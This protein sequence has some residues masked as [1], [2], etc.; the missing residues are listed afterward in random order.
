M[1]PE[2][3]EVAIPISMSLNEAF[4]YLLPSDL[5][6]AV[7]VGCRVIVPFR[8]ISI[9][10]YV[11]AIKKS[12]PYKDKLKNI[13]KNLDTEPP[14]NDEMFELADLLQKRYFCSTADAIHTVLP[15]GL[16]KSTRQIA[17]TDTTMRPYG[18]IAPI[19]EEE[20]S[21]LSNKELSKSPVL[22]HDLSDKKRWAAY[23]ALIK[24]ALAGKKSVIFMVPDHHK[25]KPAIERL[26]IGI[27]PL[28]LS[29]NIKTSES[30][31]AWFQAKNSDFVFLVGTRSAV[32]SPVN[33][34]GLIIIEEEDHFAYRQDQVP[35]Y[36]TA[37][38]AEHRARKHSAKL[39]CGS[40]MPSLESFHN[41]KTHSG[42]YIKFGELNKD[43][44][45]K[46]IDMK[47]QRR[48]KPKERVIS[49]VLEHRLAAILE[50]KQ[51]VLIFSNKKGFSTFLY[52]K[53]CN[54]TQTCPRCSTSLVYHFNEKLLSCPKCPHTQEPT[55]LC[56][57]C[58]SAYV[59][60]S[61]YGIEKVESEISR[62]FPSAKVAIYGKNKN[63]DYD[64]IL[65]TQN[66]LEDP[67][68]GRYSCDAVVALSCEQM[69]GHLDFHS[70]EKA[71][72]KLAK[73]LFLAK[74]EFLA[75]TQVMENSALDCLSRRDTE[76]FYS[77]ELN[78]RQ[79][80]SLPPFTEIATLLIRSKK[81]ANAEK[82]AKE[83]F[84][85]LSKRIKNTAEIELFGPSQAR[86][87]K[88]RGNY[89]YQVLIK[90]KNADM[91]LRIADPVVKKRVAGVIV[92]LDPESSSI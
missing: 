24:K 85:S 15:S 20:N 61:G 59:K 1:K 82:S 6:P 90:Y 63:D 44:E 62:L 21:F 56:P 34:L 92:T 36:R 2:I 9:M 40:F 35:H 84:K 33:N 16:K 74:K 31:E 12:S 58:K 3:A 66:L 79:E 55:D 60:Y 22:I 57:V 11:T 39:V 70:T 48:F 91:L 75:Q 88:V 41:I 4:D 25:I 46:L 23:S 14:L 69:L 29:S 80:L 87:L 7:K 67:D 86:P 26:K 53:R 50:Q 89:R 28:I 49:T 38:L 83:I 43:A 17:E 65:T 54:T 76:A 52:C 18:D 64:I 68:W 13:I 78:E 42:V 8:N 32:F 71:F 81:E 77:N 10:G 45:I 47:T 30:I 27:K 73:L 5:K 37:F 19:T 72:S 51:K